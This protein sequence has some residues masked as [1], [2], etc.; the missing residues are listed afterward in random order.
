MM[1]AFL[2][3]LHDQGCRIVRLVPAAAPVQS[4]PTELLIEGTR[5]DLSSASG[6]RIH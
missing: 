3:Y 5:L 2:R 4:T 1:P 6:P